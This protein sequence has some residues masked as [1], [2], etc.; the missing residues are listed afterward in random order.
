MDIWAVTIFAR[1]QD[2]LLLYEEPDCDLRK[3][4][5]QRDA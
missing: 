1:F 5:L 3:K 2:S 4:A